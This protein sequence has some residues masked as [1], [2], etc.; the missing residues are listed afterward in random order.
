M[1]TDASKTFTI[2]TDIKAEQTRKEKKSQ[3][4]LALDL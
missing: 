4:I 2:Y 1:N 3:S